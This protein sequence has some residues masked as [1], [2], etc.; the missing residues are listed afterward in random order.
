M[1][2]RDRY[3]N[4]TA[5]DD[6]RLLRRTTSETAH[7]LRNDA[8][9][10]GLNLCHAHTRTAINPPADVGQLRLAQ[11][12]PHRLAQVRKSPS[13]L[14]S[15]PPPS[16]SARDE[17]LSPDHRHT[18]LPSTADDVLACANEPHP[19]DQL[20]SHC[21][22]Y[23]FLQPH[24]ASKLIIPTGCTKKVTGSQDDDSVGELTERRPL[25]GSWGVSLHRA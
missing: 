25:C 10:P 14:A 16:P 22:P 3:G 4:Q 24:P 1:R 23:P 11:L 2:L 12:S 7:S 9:A 5:G 19:F 20:R 6:L 21:C 18:A 15:P 8:P 17:A 13:H